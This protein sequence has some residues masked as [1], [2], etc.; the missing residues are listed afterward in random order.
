MPVDPRGRILCVTSNF[1]RWKGD[2]TPEFVL[3]LAQDLQA[4]G[5]SVDVLAPH[6]PGAAL[7]ENFDGIHV[8]R[9]RY[10]WP[11]SEQTICYGGGA[12]ANL[13]NNP[14]DRLKLPALV[15]G[16]WAGLVHRLRKGHYDLIHSHWLLPQGFVG[17][18]AA[19]MTK[20]P[21]I[22]TVH[23][24]DVLALK[25]PVID[26]FKR[27]AIETSDAVTANSSATRLAAKTLGP[28][29]NNIRTIPMGVSEPRAPDPAKLKA[30]RAQYRRPNGPLL[31]FA[32]RIVIEKGTEEL[33][34]AIKRLTETLPDVTALI[35]GDGPD[36]MAMEHDVKRKNLQDHVSFSGWVPPEDLPDYFAAAD[37]VVGPSWFEAQGLVFA[38][39]MLANRPVIAT[40]VGG[41]SDTVRH[42]ETGLLIPAKSPHE[43]TAAVERLHREPELALRLASTGH[44]YV[45]GNLMRPQ[46]AR[47]FSDLFETTIADRSRN[48]ARDDKTGKLS[49]KTV[50]QS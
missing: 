12:L 43:I 41:V 37:M 23:G 29:A 33:I 40:D 28:S 30:L 27:F 31:V 36:R 15:V 5:W 39:A 49:E 7:S 34:T 17:A 2:T 50:R 11:Q 25:G 22:A 4:L 42:G 26:R 16:E 19:L 13:R 8:E 46:A 38:E 9:F 10:F 44:D 6:A 14:I 48:S 35:V 1:P 3:H 21:H 32:G 18:M 20:T 45:H 47:A 24:S